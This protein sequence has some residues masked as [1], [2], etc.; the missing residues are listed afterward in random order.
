MNN[1]VN[2]LDDVVNEV[3]SLRRQGD[4]VHYS[5]I[6]RNN[7]HLMPKLADRL[8]QLQGVERAAKM[9]NCES[10]V[11]ENL[12]T[13][14]HDDIEF[15]RQSLPK[16]KIIN[17]LYRGGQG[18]IY[19]AIQ[20]A[21]HRE[22]V[23]KVLLDGPLATD[24]QRR[25]FSQEIELISKLQHPNIVTLYEAGV[26]RGR[27]FYVMEYVDGHSIDDFVLLNQYTLREI[28]TIFTKV[29]D[30]VSAAHQIGIIHRDLK[31]SNII[32]DQDGVPHVLDFG[33]AK[34][35]SN[36]DTTDVNHLT[37]SG[38]IVGTLPYLSPEAVNSQSSPA[39][40]RSDVYSLAII[41]FEIITG[42]YP[43]PVK[44]QT[45]DIIKTIVEHEPL[46]ITKVL[47]H[48]DIYA[49]NKLQEI[50]DD[51]ERII[52]K[53]L[54][55]QPDQRYQSVGE[56]TKD[57]KHFL[58]GDPISIK[59]THLVY[60]GKKIILKYRKQFAIL[61]I[62]LMALIST[63]VVTTI[64]WRKAESL[65]KSY[66]SGLQAGSFNN[67]A[68]LDRDAG[69]V[70]PAIEMLKSSISLS[71][72][73]DQRDPLVMRHVYD[74][75]HR[76]AELYLDLNRT[77]ES[78]PYVQSALRI[79]QSMANRFP[80]QSVWLRLTA[81]SFVLQ[82]KLYKNQGDI[83]SSITSS[84]SAI[85]IYRKLSNIDTDSIVHTRDLSYSLGELS[86]CLIKLKKYD[87][88]L[89][90]I[91]EAIQLRNNIIALDPNHIN[92]EIELIRLKSLLGYMYISMKRHSNDILARDVLLDSKSRIE[93]VRESTDGE[94]RLRDIIALQKNIDSNLALVKRRLAQP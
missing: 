72:F 90:A 20:I 50:N 41:L 8:K 27:E 52:H 78:I 6:I 32:V 70:D 88:S 77:E 5:R 68:S 62:L 51:L 23:I 15:L 47:R 13:T 46:S 66:Q 69:R 76:L 12:Q 82:G 63:A 75:N 86:H 87:G 49:T 57:L 37:L 81:F 29:C 48:A 43:Y 74:A 19:K 71:E 14:F 64:S 53:C 16:Y 92:D 28:I 94:S 54:E 11:E 89:E 7:F 73:M 42:C 35:S 58:S 26:I 24:R 25:R 34:Y 4:P 9:V 93:R 10:N 91:Q 83:K 67:L 31:P 60:V 85:N 80:D 84:H 56:F 22:V 44:G 33:L 2:T 21:T 17:N 59:S 65:A 30:A 61:C 1:N 39:D 3:I 36:L 38:Q 55:K 45:I 18:A 40:V 79:A